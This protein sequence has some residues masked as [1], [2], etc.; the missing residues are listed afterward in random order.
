MVLVLVLE[1]F[2]QFLQDMVFRLGME[3]VSLQDRVLFL[4]QARELRKELAVVSERQPVAERPQL[5][6]AVQRRRQFCIPVL[7]PVL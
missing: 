7:E 2:S 5:L 3:R 1:P 4:L 6:V